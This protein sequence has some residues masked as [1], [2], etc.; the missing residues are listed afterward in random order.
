M[1]ERYAHWSKNFKFVIYYNFQF[2][3]Y[4]NELSQNAKSIKER[5]FLFALYITNSII[6]FKSL[7][8]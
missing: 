7:W 6:F 3:G 8:E 1:T 5:D 4:F 2:I